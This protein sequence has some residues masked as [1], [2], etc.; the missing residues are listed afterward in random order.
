MSN[1]RIERTKNFF[2]RSECEALNAWVDEGV[3][4]KW[5]DKGIS[6]GW[7]LNYP[8]RVTSRMYA[9]RYEYPQLVRDLSFRIRKFCG[10]DDYPLIEG[11]GRDGVVVS[12]T[13]PGGNVY[14]HM[15][16]TSPSGMA[17]LRC[18]VMTRAADVGCILHIAGQAV[19]IEVGELHCYLASE[20]E[21]FATQVEGATSRVMWMFGAHAPADDWNSGKI[22]F[23]V[24]Q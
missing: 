3:K 16:P 18:N 6:P 14:A 24:K 8:Y 10:I 5:L 22:K 11:H 15:D 9:D 19:D 20:H 21:H 23:G 7:S 13:F 17:T 4:N 12:C 1:L 2:S